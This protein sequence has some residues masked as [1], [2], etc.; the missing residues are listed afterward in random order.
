MGLRHP[1]TTSS[2]PG[3][4]SPGRHTIVRALL[5][6]RAATE[7]VPDDLC[8]VHDFALPHRP[9]ALLL[10]AG[11][12]VALK[13]D[14]AALMDD[15]RATIPAALDSDDH[16]ARRRAVAEEL[17][18]RHE[19]DIE[20]IRTDAKAHGFALMHSPMGFALAP[21]K[22]G[23]VLATADFE[24]L[25]EDERAR[26]ET[27]MVRLQD[28]LREALDRLPQV[29][30]LLRERLKQLVEASVA[31]RRSSPTSSRRWP[32]G[33]PRG[34]R[35][36]RRAPP[37]RA[38]A[39]GDA[40]Q[41]VCLGRRRRRPPSGRAEARRDRRVAPVPRPRARGPHRRDRRRRPRGPPD[42]RQPRRRVEY[43]AQLG[44]LVT[45]FNLIRPG[46]S[47]RAR[48]LS[49]DARELLSQPY[50]WE[51]SSARCGAG[52]CASSPSGRCSRS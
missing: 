9:R 7:P 35:L 26:L 38:R 16:K 25:P 14:V 45:D 31:A 39:R 19:E 17:K 22:D 47:P 11:R 4:R 10:P 5:A 50:A 37:R 21:V 43:A 27:E 48:Q 1:A 51:V 24:K 23:D 6:A 44:A 18:A 30:R 32:A 49:L 8:Y 20:S 3:H 12:G 36:P 42:L 13:R 15:V 41:G 33:A 34:G 40:R 46:A 29:E 2:S 52:R 28:R